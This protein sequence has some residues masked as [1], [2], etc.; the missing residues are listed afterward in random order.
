M[1]ASRANEGV[2]RPQ[3]NSP[4]RG[5]SRGW[6][7]PRAAAYFILVESTVTAELS[8]AEVAL[9]GTTTAVF[10]VSVVLGWSLQEA[11]NDKA[12]R[13]GAASQRARGA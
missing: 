1:C 4:G 13:A 10:S 7:K 12:V 5:S 9:L 3:T 11:S 8:E 6:G 2:G